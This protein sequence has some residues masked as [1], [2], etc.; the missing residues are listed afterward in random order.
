MRSSA[1]SVWRW[2]WVKLGSY[3]IYLLILTYFALLIPRI[4]TF[5]A[6]IVGIALVALIILAGLVVLAYL[7]EH[8]SRT[9]VAENGLMIDMGILG[10]PHRVLQIA[11][12]EVVQFTTTHKGPIW[13]LKLRLIGADYSWVVSKGF[14]DLVENQLQRFK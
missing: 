10:G 4:L 12:A 5:G 13:A 6:S 14:A 8:P 7:R 11:P 3:F 1:T 9:R 2:N